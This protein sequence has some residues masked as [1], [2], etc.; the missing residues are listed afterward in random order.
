MRGAL[1]LNAPGPETFTLN[2]RNVLL[3]R[4]RWT[5]TMRRRLGA[6]LATLLA[7]GAGGAVFSS[8]ASALAIGWQCN[9]LSPNTWCTTNVNHSY[10]AVKATWADSGNSLA[11]CAKLNVQ[12][13][14]PE[15]IYARNC[16][17]ALAVWA[18]TSTTCTCLNALVA[19]GNNSSARTIYGWATT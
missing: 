8:S 9:G 4:A 17:T 6:T 16:Q 2:E 12:G 1:T 15:I 11:M 13:A 14:Y 5:F 10:V 7:V 3:P 18:N 19:N